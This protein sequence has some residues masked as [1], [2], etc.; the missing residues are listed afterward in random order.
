MLNLTEWENP[1]V[2]K[3]EQWGVL[4]TVNRQGEPWELAP[5]GKTNQPCLHPSPPSRLILLLVA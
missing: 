4:S 5:P 1:G 2:R 3:T